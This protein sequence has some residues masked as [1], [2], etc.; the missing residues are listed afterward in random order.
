[1]EAAQRVRIDA[2]YVFTFVDTFQLCLESLVLVGGS[3]DWSWCCSWLH[4]FERRQDVR[5][6][7]N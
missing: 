7:E 4:N 1:M 2:G 3:E 6:P 5:G